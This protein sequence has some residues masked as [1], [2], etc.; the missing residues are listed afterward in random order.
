MQLTRGGEYGILGVFYL[1]KQPPGKVVLL[2]EIANSQDIP[3]S[4][5]AKIFQ[6][7]S[8][9]NIIRSVRGAKGGF[10]LA[11]SPETITVREILE[12]IEGPMRLSDCLVGPDLCA[13]RPHCPL[14]LVWLEIHRQVTDILEKTTIAGLME[15]QRLD[16]PSPLFLP[17]P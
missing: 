17:Q 15:M 3:Q 10:T 11:R 8:R 4:F 12:V 16:L 13:R 2:S 14:Q 6:Q 7:L 9:V 1:A 5:L